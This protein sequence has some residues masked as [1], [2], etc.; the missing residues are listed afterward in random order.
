MQAS[1]WATVWAT[2][3]GAAAVKETDQVWTLGPTDSSRSDSGVMRLT[4]GADAAL[5]SPREVQS[6]SQFERLGD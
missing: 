4:A 1:A 6:R 3:L 5:L 2:C